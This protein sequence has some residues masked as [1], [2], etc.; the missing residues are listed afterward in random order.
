MIQVAHGYCTSDAVV[1]FG[2]FDFNLI[3]LQQVMSV[4]YGLIIHRFLNRTIDEPSSSGKQN[5]SKGFTKERK[6]VT[7]LCVAL[8]IT[9]F[10]CWILFHAVQLAKLS[11]LPFS[12]SSDSI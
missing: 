11:Y 4:C 6:K 1:D 2:S 12:V 5:K 7:Q 10:L 8:V 3:C 9:F